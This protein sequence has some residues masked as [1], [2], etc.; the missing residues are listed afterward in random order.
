VLVANFNSS[1]KRRNAF[2]LLVV[3]P[4]ATPVLEHGIVW[5][6]TAAQVELQYDVLLTL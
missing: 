1:K 3:K 2:K 4:F 5:E 6:I